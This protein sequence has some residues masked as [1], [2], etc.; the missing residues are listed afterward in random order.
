M[1]IRNPFIFLLGRPGCGKSAVY[2]ILVELFKNER[3]ADEFER[4][5]DFPI[6]KELLDKDVEFKRHIRKDGGF[7]VTD[8]S[9]VDEVLQVINK[10]AL[11]KVKNNKIIFIEFARDNYINALK[12]FD[13]DFL[14]NSIVLYIQ[15]DFDV[16]LKRNEKRFKELGGKD[17]DAHIVPPDL[18]KSYYKNDDIENI[19][20][21]KGKESL[22][23][24]FPVKI[25]VIENN[26][27]G[28]EALK[29]K[30]N[31][32]VKFYKLNRV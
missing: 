5:D 27:E 8:W 10:K 20:L 28:I 25:F 19:I 12:N 15:C 29:S 26:E 30:L 4:I 18:M 17:I 11:E 24:S 7:A 21:E 3:I 22:I 23:K 16:C 13:K 1:E 6:L 14:N 31:E 2:K 32:F 9:I